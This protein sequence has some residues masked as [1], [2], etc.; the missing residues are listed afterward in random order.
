MKVGD[1]VTRQYPNPLIKL[2][3]GIVVEVD[4]LSIPDWIVAVFPNSNRKHMR[5][6][7]DRK[8]SFQLLTKL[9]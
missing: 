6:I 3:I 1:L 4:E 2:G 7:C 8:S 5:R 9:K